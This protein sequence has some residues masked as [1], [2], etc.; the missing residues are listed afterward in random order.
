MKFL[1]RTRDGENAEGKVRIYFTCHE[2]DFEEYFED[3]CAQIFEVLDCAVYYTEDME[4]WY[5][6]E[7]LVGNLEMMDAIVIPITYAWCANR[8][9]SHETEYFYAL[10]SGIPVIPLMAEANSEKFYNTSLLFYH[11]RPYNL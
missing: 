2:D 3:V 5:S 6:Y 8:N 10:E 9:R 4:S 1:F 7:D 11:L